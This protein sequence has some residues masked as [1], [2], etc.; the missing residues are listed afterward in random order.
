MH[1]KGYA[2]FTSG[3]MTHLWKNVLGG[4]DKYG[5]YITKHQWMW[6]QNWVPVVE[7]YCRKEND[8]TPPAHEKQLYAKDIVELMHKQGYEKFSTYWLE[9]LWKYEMKIDRNNSPYGYFDRNNR[10]V[11]KNEWIPIVIDY[12]KNKW[13]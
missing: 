6:Y 3:T 5:I 8:R 10:F 1:E 9:S 4:R 7:D 11:W 12:C 13:K 2:W